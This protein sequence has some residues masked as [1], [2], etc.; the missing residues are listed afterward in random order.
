LLK[1][2][3]FFFLENLC[4]SLLEVTLEAFLLLPD[5]QSPLELLSLVVLNM[6]PYFGDSICFEPVNSHLVF[7]RLLPRVKDFRLELVALK[8][9][10]DIIVLLSGFERL[11]SIIVPSVKGFLHFE[12]T[13]AVHGAGKVLELN[14]TR[15]IELAVVGELVENL[16]SPDFDA[17]L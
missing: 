4:D 13:Q 3:R 10:R 8:H 9:H 1:L 12:L 14:V 16:L 15:V 6:V 2:A 7:V 11:Q 5:I 17:S